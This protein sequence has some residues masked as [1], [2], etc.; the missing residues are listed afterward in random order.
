MLV[1]TPS[2]ENTGTQ[3][4][5]SPIDVSYLT[6]ATAREIIRN[7]E[8]RHN[9]AAFGADSLRFLSA[10]R[11]NA[12]FPYVSPDVA[13]PGSPQ[14]V[15]M[16]AGLNDN[17]GYVTAFRFIVTFSEWIKRHTSGVILLQL[18]ENDVLQT[19]YQHANLLVRLMRPMG[20]L[21]GDW[22]Y[23]QE[24]NYQEMLSSLDELLPGKFQRMRLSFGSFKNRIS[25]SWHLTQ[26]EKQFLMK[27]IHQPENKETIRKLK[28]VLE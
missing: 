18:Q 1:L 16:D 24:S 13:L 8:F 7:I 3:L 23:V 4:V 25:L 17:F 22:A 2:I 15:V 9:Y 27:S 12:S 10:I 28:K 11:M 21:F 14:L 19:Y 26:K 5:I 20:S 6:K